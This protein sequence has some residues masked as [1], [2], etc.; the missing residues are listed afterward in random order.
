MTPPIVIAPFVPVAIPIAATMPDNSVAVIVEGPVAKAGGAIGA[1]ARPITG[2]VPITRAVPIP[3]TVPITR[4]PPRVETRVVEA[5]KAIGGKAR[6]RVRERAV[7]KGGSGGE[8]GRGIMKARAATVKTGPSAM[9]PRP[10]TGKSS[11]GRG[12]VPG[13]AGTER[14]PAPPIV[15]LGRLQHCDAHDDHPA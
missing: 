1:K 14:T 2:A 4:S 11:R 8:T 10:A 9:K 13:P 3:G 12:K 7:P 5:V 6:T 15:G